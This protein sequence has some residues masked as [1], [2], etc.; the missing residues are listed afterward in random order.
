MSEANIADWPTRPEKFGMIPE[1]TIAVPVVG[2]AANGG[3]SGSAALGGGLLFSF[4]LGF[5]IGQQ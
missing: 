5:L 2:S 1:F 3:E 4:K